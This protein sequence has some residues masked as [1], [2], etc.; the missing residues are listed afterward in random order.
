MRLA[1]L[2]TWS[3]T[4][5]LLLAARGSS[6]IQTPKEGS[7][8]RVDILEN[9][10]G[11]RVLEDKDLYLQAVAEAASKQL[12][13]L[14]KE[15][16][17]TRG[18]R[19]PR[20]SVSA[21]TSV[22]LRRTTF[23]GE[24]LY[25]VAGKAVMR[26]PAA[27]SLTEVQEELGDQGLGTKVFDGYRPYE[28]TERMW[29]LVRTPTTS[30]IPVKDPVTIEAAW[31]TLRSLTATVK[32]CSCSKL[33][34]LQREDRTRLRGPVR[35]HHTQPRPPARGDKEPRLR[36][37]RNVVVPLRLPGL[38]VVQVTEPPTGERAIV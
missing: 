18:L 21:S 30:P 38:R 11:L 37:A 13:E 5:L 16:F 25:P 29:D 4:V 33:R 1:S 10:Y 22:T 17:S 2:V 8:S 24:Q 3:V 9:A 14:Q 31:W 26:K 15:V 23:M 6:T 7:A 19:Y 34:G 12:V 27:E 36:R 32:S 35:R 20:S 28:V